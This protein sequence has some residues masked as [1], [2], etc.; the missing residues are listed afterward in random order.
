MRL[1]Y[2]EDYMLLSPNGAFFY[3]RSF[4]ILQT[5]KKIALF[6]ERKAEEVKRN[7][8]SA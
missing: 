8:I 3:A 1:V 4:N 5:R 2:I 6:G 7:V